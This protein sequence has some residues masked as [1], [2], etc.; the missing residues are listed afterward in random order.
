LFEHGAADR[1]VRG[2][3]LGEHSTM[4]RVGSHSSVSSSDF[5]QPKS[6]P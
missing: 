1:L 5:A 4:A 3:E 6:R 2:H